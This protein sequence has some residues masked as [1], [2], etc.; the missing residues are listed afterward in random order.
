MVGGIDPCSRYDVK[1]VLGSGELLLASLGPYYEAVPEQDLARVG[2]EDG[3]QLHRPQLA[4]AVTAA[5]TNAS[6][7]SLGWGALCALSMS[8][9]YRQVTTS[10][11]FNQRP[12]FIYRCLHNTL[13]SSQED[14]EY[15]PLKTI[16]TENSQVQVLNVVNFLLCM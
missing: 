6:T 5:Q 11:A 15:I 16:R 9:Y 4:A 10:T 7:L 1:L 8:V 3:E 12:A 13:P 2:L 14:G